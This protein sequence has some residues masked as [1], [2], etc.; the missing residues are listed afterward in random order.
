[1]VPRDREG[2]Q[3]S[4]RPRTTLDDASVRKR[5]RVDVRPISLVPLRDVSTMHDDDRV[6]GLAPAA[7][8]A[9]AS[10]RPSPW[11]VRPWLTASNSMAS[12]PSLSDDARSTSISS[13]SAAV[14]A[15]CGFP[16]AF[17]LAELC[18]V[19]SCARSSACASVA[20]FFGLVEAAG[21]ATAGSATAAADLAATARLAAA[22]DALAG[23]QRRRSRDPR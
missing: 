15:V 16:A 14:T 20:F 21:S 1:M 6:M 5:R 7:I 4:L 12:G 2:T 23:A 17:L 3:R 13:S 9:S 22:C 11:P 10:T 8:V 18:C 19:R